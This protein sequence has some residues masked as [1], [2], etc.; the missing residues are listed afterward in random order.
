MSPSYSLSFSLSHYNSKL[1][2]VVFIIFQWF[3]C[4]AQSVFLKLIFTSHLSLLLFL[5]IILN[6]FHEPLIWTTERIN[7]NIRMSN[8]FTVF[9]VF[10]FIFFFSFIFSVFRCW[11]VL[12]F[13]FLPV[14]CIFSLFSCLVRSVLYCFFF[15]FRI[16]FSF[17]FIIFLMCWYRPLPWSSRFKL[18]LETTPCG[19]ELAL[20]T[21]S[22]MLYSHI[23]LQIYAET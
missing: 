21:K 1:H 18:R 4:R 12:V 20:G 14:C 11:S 16:H 17:S 22:Y 3:I 23:H 19:R 13:F 6:S 2:I 5:I 9:G 7:Y 10:L 15:F 8:L